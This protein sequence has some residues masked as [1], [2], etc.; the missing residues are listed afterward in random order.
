MVG[1]DGVVVTVVWCAPPRPLPLEHKS[2]TKVNI[3]PGLLSSGQ[4]NRRGAPYLDPGR[5]LGRGEEA[6]A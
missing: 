2:M 6:E 5:H 4:Q 1:A 3:T